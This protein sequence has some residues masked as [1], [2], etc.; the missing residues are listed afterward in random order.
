MDLNFLP[1]NLRQALSNLNLNFL[2]EIRMRKGQAVI[3]EYKGEYKYVNSFGALDRCKC[4]E[5]NNAI[6]AEDIENLLNKAMSGSVYAYNEQLKQGYI[7]IGGG[8]RIG[9]SG[10]YVYEKNQIVALRN[11]TSINI[12]IP[13]DVNGCS[14]KIFSTIYN[15]VL[16]N[17]LIFSQPGLGKT[18]IL[19]D[20]I[21]NLS[22]NFFC[23]IL[24]FDERNEISGMSA[25]TFSYN[26][27]QTVD[28]V[29]GQKKLYAFKNAIRAMKPKIIVTDELYGD[30]DFEAAKLAIE[31]GIYVIASTHIVSIDK[32]KDYPFEFFVKL[33]KIGAEPII[34]DKNFNT[35]CNNYF[36][37]NARLRTV[38]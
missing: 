7:T 8:I 13:H 11:I 16:H 22:K 15:N 27:G 9:V 33:N 31:C 28:V 23:N 12:R 32:L 14:N 37:D 21:K 3:I 26:L 4:G 2:T 20:L 18:T 5:F 35:V 36:D 1:Y 29:I 19:R 6:I 17:T 34:Y 38:N 24:V 25:G 10:E 30:D